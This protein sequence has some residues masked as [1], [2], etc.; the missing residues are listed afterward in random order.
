M[1]TFTAAQAAALIKAALDSKAITLG[2][3]GGGA[4]PASA[5]QKDAAYLIA[6]LNSLQHQAP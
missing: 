6:L 5:G 3:P 4:T 1:E 2:G